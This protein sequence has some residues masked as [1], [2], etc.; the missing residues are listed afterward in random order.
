MET[1]EQINALIEEA[2]NNLDN[3]N[4][5]AASTIAQVAIAEY[6]GKIAANLDLYVGSH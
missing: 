1:L 5:S 6:L 2:K 3:G 4:L